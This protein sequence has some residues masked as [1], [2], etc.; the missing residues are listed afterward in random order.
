M[1]TASFLSPT[2]FYEFDYVAGAWTPVTYY[3]GLEYETEAEALA[4]ARTRV[5]WLGDVLDAGMR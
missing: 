4:A 1:A 2:Y 5:A 3:S